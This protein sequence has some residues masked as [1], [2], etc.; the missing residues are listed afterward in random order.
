M[1]RVVGVISGKGGV[2]KTIVS[3]NLAAALH[4]Y[5]GKKTLV[6]DC[7]ITT[8]HVGLYLG[9]YST[10]ATLNDALKGHIPIEKAIYEHPSGISIIPASLKL[11]DLQDVDWHIVKEKLSGI[12]D[13]YE[14]II[15]DSSPGFNRESL[16]T[17]EAAHEALLVTNPIVHSTADLIKCRKLC[18]E[19]HIKPLG[20]VL[21][22]VRN[23]KYEIKKREV[24]RMVGLPVIASI[25]FNEKVME[26][27][28][29]KTP[30]IAKSR[31]INACFRHLSDFMAEGSLLFEDDEGFIGKIAGLLHVGKR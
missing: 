31:R 5:H 12:L 26:S 7:N 2:G 16:I 23:K 29:E 19:L 27:L 28:V 3:I 4:K 15:L 18:E 22:M 9:I 10:P 21:N 20:V 11:E 30:A 1:S 14:F 6:V 24:E 13:K 17:L 25:P 8:S